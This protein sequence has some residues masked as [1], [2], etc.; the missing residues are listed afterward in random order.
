MEEK[1]LEIKDLSVEYT[2]DEDIVKAVNHVSL[3]LN[4]G[5]TIGLVGE[6]GAGKTTLA[7]SLMRLLP[8]V[9]GRITG[10]EIMFNGEDL[11]KAAEEDMRKVRG[12]KISMIFQDP[13]TSLNPVL[14]VGNQIGEALELHMDLTPEKKQERIEEMLKLVG[15]A[16]SRKKDYP[17]SFRGYEAAC[18]HS[19]GPGLQA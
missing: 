9:S 15:I 4:K 1:L 18:G 12:E 8:K 5:E 3:T 7:L 17:I 6:T 11:V 2:T 14:T 16:E 19:N 13:M 10:G